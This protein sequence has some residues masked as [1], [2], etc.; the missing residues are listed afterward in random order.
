MLTA[1]KSYAFI[2]DDG[3][4]LDGNEDDLSEDCF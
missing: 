3:S 2:L 4:I 1:F